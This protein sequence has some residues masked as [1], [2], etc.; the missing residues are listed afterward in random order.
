[1]SGVVLFFITLKSIW[2]DPQVRHHLYI[3]TLLYFIFDIFRKYLVYVLLFYC[4]FLHRNL[5]QA[6]HVYWV[7][8]V[9]RHCVKCIFI[10]TAMS[11][12]C[13]SKLQVGFLL[14]TYG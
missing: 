6:Y 9:Y 11:A 2:I 3:V 1:M 12:F 5:I 14:F 10:S 4:L 13:V 7:W 8:F